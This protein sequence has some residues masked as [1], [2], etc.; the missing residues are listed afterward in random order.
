MR[1]QGTQVTTQACAVLFIRDS[2]EDISPTLPHVPVCM[3]SVSW[4]N[5]LYFNVCR[6]TQNHNILITCNTLQI[7]PI[8]T[9]NTHSRL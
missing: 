5:F 4:L 7:T 8:L 1:A 3:G 6:T 2:D 9:C